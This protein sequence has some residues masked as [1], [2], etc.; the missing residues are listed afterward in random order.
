MKAP[1]A[2][3]LLSLGLSLTLNFQSVSSSEINLDAGKPLNPPP[4]DFTPPDESTYHQIKSTRSRRM[5]EQRERVREKIASGEF[6]EKYHRIT[7]E[8]LTSLVDKAYDEDPNL[9]KVEHQWIRRG[10]LRE[11]MNDPR[12][13]RNLNEKEQERNLWGFF[14]SS[15]NRDPYTPASGMA[16]SGGDYDKWAQGFVTSGTLSIV[17]VCS[18]MGAVPVIMVETTEW[19]VTVG[20]HGVPT[21][22]RFML[23]ENMRSIMGIIPWG[24]WIVISLIRNGCFW[25]VMPRSIISGMNRFRS[26]CGELVF[27]F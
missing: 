25:G 4:S 10:N 2:A 16:D 15:T 13:R 26:I 14:G 19:S 18:T 20:R 8:Q 9:D 23:G 12:R 6:A 27:I 5:A 7:E 22:I 1:I 24:V 21:L 11:A 3:F 17:R